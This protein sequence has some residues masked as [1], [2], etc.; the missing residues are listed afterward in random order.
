MRN[1]GSNRISSILDDAFSFLVRHN[2]F[3]RVGITAAETGVP[4]SLVSRTTFLG[5]LAAHLVEEVR[6]RQIVRR[7][8]TTKAGGSLA[9]TVLRRPATLHFEPN[10]LAW[11]ERMRR[12]FENGLGDRHCSF[13]MP[14]FQ[15]L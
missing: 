8:R 1:I 4:V 14:Y 13:Q 11:L 7:Q 10:Q 2:A 6:R 15:W 5:L 12:K 9:T 3:V